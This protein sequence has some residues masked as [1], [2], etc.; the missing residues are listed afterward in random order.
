MKKFSEQDEYYCFF[1]AVTL[2]LLTLPD[3]LIGTALVI[4]EKV[5][6][7]MLRNLRP[8]GL[9]FLNIIQKLFLR[10]MSLNA[11]FKFFIVGKL[12]D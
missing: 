6:S 2:P 12:N 11:I 5:S 3:K 9:R 4:F 8:I 10:E 7:E 1:C